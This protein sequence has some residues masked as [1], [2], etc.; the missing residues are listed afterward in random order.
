MKE[1]IESEINVLDLIQVDN[2]RRSDIFSDGFF[3]LNS[4][5]Q[6]L[7]M[8][9]EN[10]QVKRVNPD[11]KEKIETI[12]DLIEDGW[13]F[14]S[15]SGY[16]IDGRYLFG[17]KSFVTK[18]DLILSIGPYSGTDEMIQVGGA[19][20]GYEGGSST[21]G[22]SNNNGLTAAKSYN[23]GTGQNNSS[24]TT[25]TSSNIKLHGQVIITLN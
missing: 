16:E 3:P 11:I 14:V 6:V 25:T 2:I 1:K 7:I 9:D 19:G 18:D 17:Q 5:I 12:D 22:Y 21:G 20:G 23:N 24:G 10:L 4:V 13:Y 8:G 15:K